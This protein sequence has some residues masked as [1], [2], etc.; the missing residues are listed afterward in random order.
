MN[1]HFLGQTSKFSFY[2]QLNVMI[3]FC[4]DVEFSFPQVDKDPHWAVDEERE[5]GSSAGAEF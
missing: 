4:A 2:L 1:F 5:Q 3:D